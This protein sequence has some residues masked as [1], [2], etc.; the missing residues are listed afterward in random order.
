[1]SGVAVN[2]EACIRTKDRAWCLNI[3]YQQALRSHGAGHR[4]E[5]PDEH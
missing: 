2:T 5:V 3:A 4:P 1:M